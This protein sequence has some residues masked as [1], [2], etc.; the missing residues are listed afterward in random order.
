MRLKRTGKLWTFLTLN[1]I[2]LS[3]F[4]IPKQCFAL[5]AVDS[6][7]VHAEGH[8]DL[9]V[10]VGRS[11]VLYSNFNCLVADLHHFEV[12]FHLLLED[13]VVQNGHSTLIHSCEHT[14]VTS[15]L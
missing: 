5:A 14:L 3:E 7:D 4:S 6:L 2:N 10:R 15:P 8:D 9:E 12:I 1:I 13:G 11:F